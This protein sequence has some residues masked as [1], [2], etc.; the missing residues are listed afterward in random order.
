MFS[1]KPVGPRGVLRKCF[2][3]DGGCVALDWVILT[4]SMAGMGLAM[5]IVLSGGPRS[6]GSSLQMAREGAPGACAEG[7]GPQVA[8]AGMG[9]PLQQFAAPADAA[10]TPSPTPS[11]APVLAAAG[12]PGLFFTDAVARP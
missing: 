9:L 10:P 5:A 2:S 8:A 4:A 6:L 11:P 7:C 3:L 1:E 12:R